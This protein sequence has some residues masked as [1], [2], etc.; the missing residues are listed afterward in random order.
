[1]LGAN[2]IS[3]NPMTSCMQISRSRTLLSKCLSWYSP[4]NSAISRLL[5]NRNPVAWGAQENALCAQMFCSSTQ[6]FTWWTPSFS[7]FGL[8]GSLKFVLVNSLERYLLDHYT[9]FQ[10]SAH[11]VMKFICCLFIFTDSNNTWCIFEFLLWCEVQL[12]WYN[13]CKF[14]CYCHFS[15]SSCK[16]CYK[17]SAQDIT[18]L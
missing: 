3:P 6:H 4:F 7:A 10:S 8:V 2:K 12:A 9:Q 11:F 18:D 5:P 16:F 17:W 13:L 15:L 14:G 1:M